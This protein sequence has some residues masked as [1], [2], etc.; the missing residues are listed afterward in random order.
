MRNLSICLLVILLILTFI[1]CSTKTS[2]VLEVGEFDNNSATK[3]FEV[4]E[5]G[6]FDNNSEA[7]HYAEIVLQNDKYKKSNIEKNKAVTLNETQLDLTYPTSKNSYFYHDNVDYYENK[8]NGK[9]TRVGI[10]SHSGRNDRY[11]Y[12]D[13]NYLDEIN[14]KSATELTRDECFDIARKYFDKYED[15]SQYTLVNERY[16]DIPEWRGTYSFEFRRVVQGI[17]TCDCAYIRITVFGDII[18]HTF[19]SLGEM[20]DA[21]LP[22]ESDIKLIEENVDKK[23]Q[24]IYSNVTDKYSVSYE[25][26]DPLFIRMADGRYAFEYFVGVDLTPK[27]DTD[28]TISEATTLIVYVD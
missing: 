14:K 17:E 27:N 20:K 21:T 8:Q 9:T 1:S 19:I 18:R 23:L 11:S 5:V 7:K 25:I 12:Y 24:D 13:K 28:S 16:D 22:S 4:L 6:E 10:N 3:T 15:T 2:E 26:P